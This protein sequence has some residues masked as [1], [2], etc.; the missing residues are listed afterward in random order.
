MSAVGWRVLPA[1]RDIFPLLKDPDQTG[2][3][4]MIRSATTADAKA[5]AEIYNHYIVHTYITFEEEP[6]SPQQMQARIVEV[7]TNHPWLVYEHSGLIEGYA[8]AS[9]WHTRCSYRRSVETTVYLDKAKL[10]K[11]IG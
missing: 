2:S 9:R 10:G 8:Y 5:I 6:V 1:N 7:Q 11:G 4:F 3:L